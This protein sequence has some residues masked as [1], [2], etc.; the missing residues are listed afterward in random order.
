MPRRNVPSREYFSPRTF[1]KRI[2]VRAR[3]RQLKT[4]GTRFI[5]AIPGP[6]MEK[7]RNVI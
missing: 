6:K 4:I 3:I 1:L 7:K 2:K 5:E